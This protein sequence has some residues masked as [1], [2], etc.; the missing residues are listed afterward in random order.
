MGITSKMIQVSEILSPYSNFVLL[1]AKLKS[2]SARTEAHNVDGDRE[3]RAHMPLWRRK[4]LNRHEV[5]CY[6]SDTISL[7]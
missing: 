6:Y 5:F 4:K 1:K 3:N 7:K 2:M